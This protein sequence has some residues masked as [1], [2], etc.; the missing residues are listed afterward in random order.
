MQPLY[1][2]SPD[3]STG[4]DHRLSDGLRSAMKAI[5]YMLNNITPRFIPHVVDEQLQAVIFADAYV[6]VDEQVHKAGY[7]PQTW[8]LPAQAR[9]DNGWGWGIGSQVI[10]C[11]GTTSH[12]VLSQITSRKAFIYEVFPQL[13]AI[14]SLAQRLPANWLAF[15]DNTF[16]E[17]AIRKG[18][19]KDAFV[20]GM[21]AAFWGTAPDSQGLSPRPTS[22]TAYLE[23]ISLGPSERTGLA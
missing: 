11:H 14:L 3:T 15:I 7:I 17:A 13:M 12:S 23:A 22:P 5:H 16:G 6:R 10:F 21:L 1:A 20:N 8:L 19:G 4:D 18:Y 9:D 2:R